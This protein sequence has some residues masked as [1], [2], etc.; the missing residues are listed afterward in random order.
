MIFGDLS[1]E[2]VEG[3]GARGARLKEEDMEPGAGEHTTDPVALYLRKM[4]TVPLLD[5]EGEVELAR[6]IE[7]GERT[8]LEALLDC[9]NAVRE[10]LALGER[11][12]HG[13]IRARDL[14]RDLDEVD[15]DEEEDEAADLMRAVCERIRELEPE[16]D[17]A[18]RRLLDARVASKGKARLAEL[19]GELRVCKER[20]VAEMRA[21]RL[22]KR[23]LERLVGTVREAIRE[24]D[25]AETELEDAAP[26]AR[27]A[28]ARLRLAA[29][30]LEVGLPISELRRT[31]E[32]LREGER[33]ADEAKGALVEANLRLVV[34]IAKKYANRGLQ[35]LD[36]VQEGNIGLMKAVDKFEYRRGY[37][38]STYATW[39]IRQSI[40]RA[41]ADQARTIRVPVHMIESINKLIRTSRRMV[42][43]TGREPTTEELAVEMEV[44]VERV[45][46]ILGVARTPI[47]LETPIGEEDGS[48]LADF[49]EDK[50]AVSPHH[51]TLTADLAIQMR[52]I[53]RNLTPREE[54]ALRMRFGIGEKP[55]HVLEQV[56]MDNP[57]TRERIR[58]ME[59]RALR[60]LRPGAQWLQGVDCEDRLEE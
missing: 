16:V 40:T 1:P 44:P 12:G 15:G 30:E 46:K 48:H 43:E 5:R 36:L 33:A 47:S 7:T 34:S 49:V 35:L 56:A 31:Y 60:K 28:S 57:V 42:Q 13:C 29:V 45:Q 32:Q 37:K 41:I 52:R 59:A 2:D 26:G 6:R 25:L 24:A 38:F 50:E 39:W 27:V 11:L 23:H 18:R 58:Q 17:H 10:L 21:V 19:H 20:M 9:R 4:G 3:R 54:K 22:D 14:L 51:A 53:L 55:D 8:V